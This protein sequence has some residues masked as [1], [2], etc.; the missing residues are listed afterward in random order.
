MPTVSVI[1]AAY[2]HEKYV[3]ETIRSVLDQTY[4]DFEMVIT[5]DGSTDGTVAEIRRFEDPRIRLFCFEQNLGACAAA[6]N[7]LDNAGGKYIAVLNS[8]DAFLPEKL[9]QQVR[10]LNEHP[11]IGAVFGRARFIDEKGW[12]AGERNHAYRD[13][14]ATANRPRH[15][16]LSHFFFEGNC[17]CHPSVLIRRECYETVGYYDPRLAQLP[18]L[19]FWVRLCLKYDIHILPEE[20]ILFRLSPGSASAGTQEH[21]LRHWW[22]FRHILDH[23][24]QITS[25][26][27][28]LRIFPEAEGFAQGLDADL[29]PFALAMVALRRTDRRRTVH[30]AFALDTLFDLLADVRTARRISARFGFEYR[31][32]IELTGRTHSHDTGGTEESRRKAK[33]NPLQAALRRLAGLEKR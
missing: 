19:D 7:C 33:T 18:D 10:F 27:D 6:G 28:F 31:D 1:I 2:N 16:W 26:A 21:R 22:E 17:L 23:Y 5:D 8:D 12:P 32:L 25:V 24:R 29:I 13:A 4:Q 20:L 3:A 11:E 30:H 14:F 9:D 15:E